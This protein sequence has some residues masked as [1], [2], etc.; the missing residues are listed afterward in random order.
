MPDENGR[1]RHGRRQVATTGDATARQGLS[2]Y[3]IGARSHDPGVMGRRSAAS[4]AS[5]DPATRELEAAVEF[6]A[7]SDRG[8][9]GFQ[10]YQH[11]EIR[12][13]PH[14]LL[15]GRG[16]Y[17]GSCLEASSEHQSLSTEIRGC[18]GRRP[19]A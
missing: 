8:R 3:M 12:G 5:L 16:Q 11:P 6:Y 2:R 19:S 17:C 1:L 4:V 15:N 18:G 9:S 7:A 13:L 14:S 10:V